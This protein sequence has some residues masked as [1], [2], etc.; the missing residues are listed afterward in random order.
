MAIQSPVLALFK[1][2]HATLK[3]KKIEFKRESTSFEITRNRQLVVLQ[4]I[5]K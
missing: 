3:E 4:Q 2:I 5:I 1:L